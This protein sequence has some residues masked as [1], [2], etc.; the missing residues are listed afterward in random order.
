MKVIGTAWVTVVITS[1]SSKHIKKDITPLDDSFCLDIVNKL[2]PCRYKYIDPTSKANN[3]FVIGFIAEDVKEFISGCV[4]TSDT[5]Y[6]P[7]HYDICEANNSNITFE[8]IHDFIVNDK[9]EFIDENDKELFH[10]VLNIIDAYNITLDAI[11][12]PQQ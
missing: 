10:A 4:N 9:I 11:L 7:S 2:K 12:E 5:E 6:I 8:K 3:D 1:S